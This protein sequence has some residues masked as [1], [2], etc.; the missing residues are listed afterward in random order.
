M[1]DLTPPFTDP[2][3]LQTRIH[4]GISATD[5]ERAVGFYRTLFGQDP[6]KLREGYAKFEVR[7][8][9]VNFT[10][11]RDPAARGSVGPQHFGIQ[12]RSADAVT[13]ARRRLESA[14]LSLEIEN[15]VTCCYAVQ[16]KVWA[17]DPDGHR[18]EVFFVRDAD[19][20][21][22]SIP[23]ER[24]VSEEDAAPCCAPTCCK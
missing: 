10:I 5:V 18:W 1:T 12:V 8:P 4:V 20:P 6:T 16:D 23:N 2:T 22:H 15:D 7:D 19:A 9:P 17:I 24:I 11:N 3:P 13:A 14:G 21:V